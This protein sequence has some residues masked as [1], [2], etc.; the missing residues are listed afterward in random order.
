M[1]LTINCWEYW[2]EK[3]NN[4]PNDVNLVSYTPTVPNETIG[5]IV[6]N[7]ENYGTITYTDAIAGTETNP[8][9]ITSPED[10]VSLFSTSESSNYIHL[11]KDIDFNNSENYKAGVVIRGDSS[12]YFFNGLNYTIRNLTLIPPDVG[13]QTRTIAYFGGNT[14]NLV[15]ENLICWFQNLIN[16][17]TLTLFKQSCNV[18]NVRI[19][20]YLINSSTCFLFYA[21]N[22]STNFTDCTFNIRGVINK[23]FVAIKCNFNRCHINLNLILKDDENTGYLLNT[24]N[25]IFSNS[26]I[27]GKL[28]F[29]YLIN[30]IGSQ[31]NS[32]GQWNGSYTCL[33]L[34]TEQ[35]LENVQ[36]S[37]NT[38]NIYSFSVFLDEEDNDI[39]FNDFDPQSISYLKL[40]SYSNATDLNFL[41]SNGFP[42][43]EVEV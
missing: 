12:Y 26:Y 3:R 27:T 10:L 8:Y 25:S 9:A 19:G 30:S 11:T 37:N 29:D 40:I 13:Y 23:I 5:E 34:I 18:I 1:A 35:I 41:L 24:I 14:S 33:K 43:V 17:S 4:L 22:Y 32:N 31:D 39:V 16:E 15:L 20:T 42:V 21:R 6:L 28:S 38:G 7:F 2:V 36:C